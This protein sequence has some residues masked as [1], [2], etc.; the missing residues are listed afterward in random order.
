M[1]QKL[2]TVFLFVLAGICL[3]QL[4]LAQDIKIAVVDIELVT[5]TSDDGKA[6]NEKLDKRFQVISA[7][8][9]KER[10]S[11]EEKETR[12]R[13]QDRLM[14]ATAKAQLSKEIEDGKT[15]FDR[16]N[17]DYQKEMVELQ[18]E[19][20]APITTKIQ[21]QLKIYVDE[22][23]PTLLIDV[24]AERGNVIW[25]NPN[26][27]ISKDLVKRVNESKT[28]A[29]ASANPP[30]AAPATTTPAAKPPVT[31]PATPQK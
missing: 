22:K 13:T 17:Q 28:P 15:K 30:A 7:E 4:S 2:K 14:S 9:D 6:M 27:D 12:L 31:T 5:Y 19:L 24:S 10:K 1:G 25:A 11:I 18:N 8:M 3:P 21:E 29:G 26:N 23:G 20:L 16:K